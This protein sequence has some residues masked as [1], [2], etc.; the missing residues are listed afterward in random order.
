M[1][2]SLFIYLFINLAAM[3]FE[4]QFKLL[5]ILT[6]TFHFISSVHFHVCN[7]FIFF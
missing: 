3:Q 1:F 5:L 6:S 7:L 2:I 4:Q